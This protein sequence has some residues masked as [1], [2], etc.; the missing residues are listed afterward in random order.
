MDGLHDEY[1]MF[2]ASNE[3]KRRIKTVSDII[4]EQTNHQVMFEE[5]IAIPHYGGNIIL[6]YN[7]LAQG[8]TLDDL[9]YYEEIMNRVAGNEFFINF[10]GRVYR[11]AG[12]DYSNIEEKFLIYQ[13][14]YHSE[15]IPQA[16][17]AEVVK[18]DARYLLS[19]CN[20][21]EDSEVWEIQVE[22]P[23]PLLILGKTNRMIKTIDGIEVSETNKDACEGLMKATVYAKRNHIS[24]GRLLAD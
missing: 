10:M 3:L 11:Q 24:F 5:Y 4:Y 14:K 12:V 9:D 6:R 2:I 15:V 1:T 18:A 13:E 19:K 17:Y 7:L 21:P 20:L 22:E 16:P 23:M 8:Y